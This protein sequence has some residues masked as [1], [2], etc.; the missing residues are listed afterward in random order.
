MERQIKYAT[1]GRRKWFLRAT[2]KI[3][4]GEE[5]TWS[6][7]WDYWLHHSRHE[8]Q[9]F[10]W[11][12]YVLQQDLEAMAVDE[13]E[14]FYWLINDNPQYSFVGYLDISDDDA[15]RIIPSTYRP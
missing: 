6:Y 13:K 10:A 4:S 12:C 1:D 8:L 2:R 3:Y 15:S 14:L 11:R 7:G 9:L 5:I